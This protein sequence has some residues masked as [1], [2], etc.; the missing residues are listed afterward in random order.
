MLG[1]CCNLGLWV[2]VKKRSF[3][4]VVVGEVLLLLM[5]LSLMLMLILL[6]RKIS[7][8]GVFTVVLMRSINKFF[9]RVVALIMSYICQEKLMCSILSVVATLGPL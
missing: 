9:T 8:S 5:Q 7:I 1:A 2:E 4:R 3:T 6:L